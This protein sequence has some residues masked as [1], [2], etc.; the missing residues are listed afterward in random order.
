M[1]CA[2]VIRQGSHTVLSF[3]TLWCRP[4]LDGNPRG[5]SLDLLG[6]H[7]D[8]VQLRRL[9]I[10]YLPECLDFKAG[11]AYR[12]DRPGLGVTADIKQLKFISSVDQ[13][14]RA[15]LYRRPDGSLTRW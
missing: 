15:N 11:N 6:S 4:D 10:P 8:G 13:L 7:I 14:G 5:V 1:L 2:G 12:N 3:L 9:S